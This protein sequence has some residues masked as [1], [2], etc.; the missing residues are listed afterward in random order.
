MRSQLD[1]PLLS[2]TTPL[3]LVTGGGPGAMEMGNR[4][5]KELDILSC[6]NIVDFQLRPDSIVNE[7][8]QN[9]YVE[10]K[11]TY[12]L[13]QLVERQAEFYLDF[14]IFVMGGIG[15]DFEFALEELRHKVG[16]RPVGPILLFG[17]P[18]YWKEKI[19]PRFQC[20]LKAGTIKGSE[21]V[22]N[23]FFCIT[24]A[25]QG[26]RLYREFFEGKIKTGPEGP[27]YDDGFVTFS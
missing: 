21:W 18:N 26:L 11:M 5:A 27:I 8:K 9:P 15:T 12:R 16:S 1:H 10:A 7:Q 2:K 6:A 13:D 20:N 24:G 17:S 25:D 3:A 19:T 14:P 22:S 23:S 4:L